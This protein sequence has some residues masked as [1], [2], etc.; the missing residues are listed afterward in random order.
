MTA[1]DLEL[2]K[3]LGFSNDEIIEANSG[4]Y[5]SIKLYKFIT[6]GVSHE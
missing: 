4:Y 5:E 1:E 3:L 6:G 2:Y